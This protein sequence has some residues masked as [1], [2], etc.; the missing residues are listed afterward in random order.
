ML[1]LSFSD[2]DTKEYV[3][4]TNPL[5]GERVLRLVSKDSQSLMF[6]TYCAIGA[7][8]GAYVNRGTIIKRK[9]AAR[10]AGRL[11]NYDDVVQEF[12]PAEAEAFF[13]KMKRYWDW[14]SR[15]LGPICATQ[16]RSVSEID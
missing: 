7:H 11:F 14:N 12:I 6:E 8:I 16:T 15:Y 9:P 3:V 1:P 10:L 4:P 2:P 5:L 13:L